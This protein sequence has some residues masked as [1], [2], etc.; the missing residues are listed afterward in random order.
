MNPVS[1]VYAAKKMKAS[2]RA[3][4]ART[5]IRADAT[6]HTANARWVIPAAQ[7][8]RMTCE[9]YGMYAAPARPLPACPAISVSDNDAS[10]PG[11][12]ARSSPTGPHTWLA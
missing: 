3:A 4:T 10:H 2:S 1:A 9:I 11:S 8:S 7:R 12:I 6:S 5:R